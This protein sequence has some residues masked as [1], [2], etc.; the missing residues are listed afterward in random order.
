[1]LVIT[2]HAALEVVIMTICGTVSDDK[3][4]TLKT[5]AFHWTVFHMHSASPE[6]CPWFP[7]CHDLLLVNFIH[8]LQGYFIGIR[9]FIWLP[10]ACAATLK[11]LG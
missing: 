1:M 10:H 7:F 11:D 6:L 2:D 5:Y 3:V 8:I 4:V 9:A